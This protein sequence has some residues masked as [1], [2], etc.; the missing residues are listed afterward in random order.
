MVVLLGVRLHALAQ[1]LAAVFGYAHNRLL[2]VCVVLTLLLVVQVL[3]SLTHCHT[4]LIPVALSDELLDDVNVL[5]YI[6]H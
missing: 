4:F 2:A 6:V 5:H 1:M 3:P